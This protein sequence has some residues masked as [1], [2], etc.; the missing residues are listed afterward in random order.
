MLKRWGN[1]ALLGLCMLWSCGNLSANCGWG[2]Y[3][4]CNYNSGCC[5]SCGN[6]YYD[7][8]P[9]DPCRWS[10]ALR[11]GV[12]PSYFSH[13][14]DTLEFVPATGQLLTFVKV[15]KFQDTTHTPWQIGGEIAWN[16]SCHVQFF[17]EGMYER[18]KAKN[19]TFQNGPL[20]LMEFEQDFQTWG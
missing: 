16:E 12:T 19:F 4:Y 1:L 9:L 15:D 5:N 6:F 7:Y 11:G 3:S 13:R 20:L 10:V 18:A 14:G 8:E 2:D 17:L